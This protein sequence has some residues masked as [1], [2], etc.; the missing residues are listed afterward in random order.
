MKTW[1]AVL[2]VFIILSS[3]SVSYSDSLRDKETVISFGSTAVISGQDICFKPLRFILS[4]KINL[5][6]ETDIYTSSGWVVLENVCFTLKRFCEYPPW[7]KGT[8]I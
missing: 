3:G 1:I 4:G 6:A 8:F 7:S 2:S 5:H